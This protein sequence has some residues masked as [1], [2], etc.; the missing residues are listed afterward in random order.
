MNEKDFKHASTAQLIDEASIKSDYENPMFDPVIEENESFTVKI[1]MEQKEISDTQT[2]S[3]VHNY[4]NTCISLNL[5]ALNSSDYLDK[6]ENDPPYDTP[7]KRS[8]KGEQREQSEDGRDLHRSREE[9]DSREG[10][11][12][13]NVET[14]ETEKAMEDLKPDLNID[15]NSNT[16]VSALDRESVIK[17]QLS[18]DS[19]YET[20]VH[21]PPP[22][23]VWFQLVQTNRQ[24]YLE[25]ETLVH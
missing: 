6:E 3:N 12:G 15:Q 1:E 17:N 9:G 4:D 14:S 13:G 5:K 7:P 10:M 19:G 11:E 25:Y 2:D 20:H 24:Q 23:C 22:N 16:E 8:F 18:V 21:S